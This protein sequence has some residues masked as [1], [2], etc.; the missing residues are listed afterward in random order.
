MN[1]SRLLSPRRWRALL[2]SSSS[3]PDGHFYAPTVDP[4]ELRSKASRLWPEAPPSTPG[5]VWD[6]ASHRQVLDELRPL[7]AEY[8]YGERPPEEEGF[9]EPNGAFE[10]LDARM[11]YGVLR[12]MRPARMIEVGSGFSTLLAAEVNARFLDGEMDFTAIEPY[13]REFLRG[14]I[15]GL[16]RLVEA[17]V[18][19]LGVEEFTQLEPG[20]I[21]FI[22]SSHVAKTGSDVN[23][24]YLEVLPRL[25]EGVVVHVHDIFLPWDYPFEWV[26]KERRNWN[27]QYLLQAMLA[28]GGRFEVLFANHYASR[29]LPDA[30]EACWGRRFGGG[31]IWLQ[32]I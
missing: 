27:E 18:Q 24:L 15:P 10:G 17:P 31:S 30:V 14:K 28:A 12:G 32:A 19:E 13:P 16:S 25:R 29:V 4:H 3:F 11:L 7:A 9:R 1:L 22:D 2:R 23:Y 20:E 6:E 26:V 5:I 21:L 8:R